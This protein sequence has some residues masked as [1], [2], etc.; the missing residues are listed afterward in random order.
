MIRRL[1]FGIRLVAYLVVLAVWLPT[2]LAFAGLTF[3][4]DRVRPPELRT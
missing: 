4:V 2:F 1:V 3:F